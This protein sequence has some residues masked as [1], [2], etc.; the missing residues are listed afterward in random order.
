MSINSDIELRVL[1]NEELI[2]EAFYQDLKKWADKTKKNVVDVVKTPGQIALLIKNLIDNPNLL[3]DVNSFFTSKLKKSSELIIK[4]FDNFDNNLEIII[5]KLKN[6]KIEGGFKFLVKF[7]EGLSKYLKKILS[8]LNDKINN[9]WLTFLIS[10]ITDTLLSYINKKISSVNL[11]INGV[12][13]KIK[14]SIQNLDGSKIKNVLNE[15]EGDFLSGVTDVFTNLNKLSGNSFDEIYKLLGFFKNKYSWLWDTTIKTLNEVGDKVKGYK[16]K[17][18]GKF[19]L[20]KKTLSS[21]LQDE[22]L[23][24]KGKKNITMNKKQIKELAYR[25]IIEGDVDGIDNPISKGELV[26]KT[27]E[28]GKNL[29]NMGLNPKERK[30]LNTAIE[31][32]TKFFSQDGN[33]AVGPVYTK[34][35]TLKKEL[36]K[37]SD[38]IKENKIQ[39]NYKKETKMKR[40]RFKKPFNGV[41]NALQLIPEN[42]K[43]DNKL[44]HMT[45]GNENYEIRWEGSLNEG[46]AVVLKAEDKNMISEN[47]SHMKHLMNY[48]SKDT[49]GEVK[50]S[51]RLDENR[52][53]S[54]V[55]NKTKVLL[56]NKDKKTNI[57]TEDNTSFP[58]KRVKVPVK[59]DNEEN[60]NKTIKGLPVKGDNEE[61]HNKTIKGLPFNGEKSKKYDKTIKGLPIKEEDDCEDEIN[62]VKDRFYEVFEG[63]ESIDEDREDYNFNHEPGESRMD[64]EIRDYER[65]E[66][67][68]QDGGGDSDH[69]TSK[70]MEIFKKYGTEVPEQLHTELAKQLKHK[71]DLKKEEKMIKSAKEAYGQDF[72]NIEEF[73]YQVEFNFFP[74]RGDFADNL[75]VGI[76]N[77]N[78]Q[79]I[80]REEEEELNSKFNLDIRDGI[81]QL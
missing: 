46:R 67:L 15:F 63:F 40:L 75:E 55:F 6:N 54:D 5:N 44:F 69:W 28:T 59:G 29:A 45:D 43:V 30:T 64:R 74:A 73:G 41:G 56:E 61:N 22:L 13:S 65:I 34:F 52:A 50:G 16:L 35:N 42:Y 3:N 10:I 38:E 58:G 27:K 8:F 39:E 66:Q 49:L 17:F 62:E 24:T 11:I 57:L 7:K 4:E 19:N 80:S 78:G 32:I 60:H 70:A 20:N 33:Q 72:N 37:L 48:N 12:V 25:I 53:F 77:Q 51:A 18:S 9:G 23:E 76:K 68:R 36:I 81:F 47:M 1:I 79:W 2:K 14:D 21:T 31:L 71:D 26:K